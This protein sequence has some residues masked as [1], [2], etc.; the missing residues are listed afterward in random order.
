MSFPERQD[1]IFQFLK[2]KQFIS[3]EDKQIH[4]QVSSFH[5]L[6]I[7]GLSDQNGLAVLGYLNNDPVSQVRRVKSKFCRIVP[8][9]SNSRP[10]YPPAE[11]HGQFFFPQQTFLHH[12]CCIKSQGFKNNICSW[13]VMPVSVATW[14]RIC[15]ISETQVA[16]GQGT[17]T[18]PLTYFQRN[19][20][21]FMPLFSLKNSLE[22]F[23]RRSI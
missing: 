2:K 9:G 14:S 5:L 22:K 8:S 16:L 18:E 4:W 1:L 7:V 3:C 15:R 6:H 13:Q 17:M 23:L 21:F 12:K 20:T 11:W 10:F 19:E